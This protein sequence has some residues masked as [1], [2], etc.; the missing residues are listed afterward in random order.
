V[1]RFLCAAVL[2]TVC[3]LASAQTITSAAAGVVGVP[4]GSGWALAAT[5]AVLALSALW[6]LRGGRR[7]QLPWLLAAVVLVGGIWNSPSLRAQILAQFTQPAGEMLPITVAPIVAGG[8]LQGFEPVDYLNASGRAL[9]I[10]AIDPPDFNDCFPATPALPLPPPGV[11]GPPACAAGGGLAVGASCRVDVDAICKALAEQ[12]T[13]II[14]LATPA[15]FSVPANSIATTVVTVDPASP[16]PAL[17]L[18]ATIPAGSNISVQST[19]CVASLAPGASCD[20]VFI[21]AVEEGPTAVAIAG[22][23]TSTL[24]LDITVAARPNISITNPVQQN[25]VVTVS[26]A[27][28]ALEVTNDVSSTSNAYGITVTNKATAP[29][30]MVDDSSCASV[31]PGASCTLLLTSNTPYAPASITIG[32]SNT[33]NTPTAVVAFSHLG[34]LVFQESGGSG[35]V[36]IDVAQGFTSSWTSTISDIGG[37][38]SLNDGQSNTNAIVA[39]AA[40]QNNLANCAAQ[41]C[42]NIGADWYLPAQNELSAVQDALCSNG[43][44][45]CT[46]GG[47]TS[48]SHWSSTQVDG[49]T[50]MAVVFPPGSA[51]ANAKS[52]NA[53]ARC[54]RAFTP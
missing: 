32:G 33:A 5:G 7:R 15:V 1:F 23:N 41:R 12:A 13:A 44:I 51:L 50:A 18:M 22:T 26:G 11:G 17:N 24:T 38:A 30:L 9:R 29:G 4:V 37:A 31:A 48:A 46:F 27:G 34:G 25:R 49:P 19:T 8:V 45:P 53:P 14:S 6:I 10:A 16:V 43:A 54:V 3:S 40:C 2:P 36:L 42:R 52:M 21:G 35:K 20:I 39:D 47:F 28:F